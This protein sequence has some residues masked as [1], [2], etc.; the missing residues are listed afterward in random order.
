[1]EVHPNNGAIYVAEDRFWATPFGI[2]Q[3]TP[4]REMQVVIARN[5][6]KRVVSLP[7]TMV[8]LSKASAPR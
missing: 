8:T 2:S 3:M 5:N 7:E 1:L 6:P 4:G